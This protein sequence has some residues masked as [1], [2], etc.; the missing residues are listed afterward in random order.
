MMQTLSGALGLTTHDAAFWM[1]LILIG[2]FFLMTVAATILDGF[3]IGVGCLLVFALPEHRLRMMG[4]LGPWRDANGFWLFLGLG[5]L[6]AAFPMGWSAIMEHLYLPMT[7]LAM[8]VLLRTAAFELRLR[9]PQT[10]QARWVKVFALGSWLMALSHG[11][12]LARLA[13]AFAPDVATAVLAAVFAGFAFAS[14]AVLGASWLVMRENGP[15]RPVAAGWGRRAVRWVAAGAVAV[16]LVLGLANTGVFLKWGREAQWGLIACVWGS[17]LLIFILLEFQLA[18]L[19]RGS[20]RLASLPFLLVVC[21][22]LVVMGGM[23]YSYFPYLV[24]DNI[25]V[26]DGAVATGS[27]MWV[28]WAALLG[29]PVAL[30]FNVWVYWGMLGPVRPVQPPPFIMR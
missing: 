3:D 18:H 4:L 28:L 11:V 19:A 5:L 20:R 15:L 8:G 14:Y 16:S 25:T 7:L 17:L 24:L 2:L 9:A 22:F 12:L 29:L 21:I 27:L 13:G 1:P 30:G 6:A 23:A 10:R 26:W